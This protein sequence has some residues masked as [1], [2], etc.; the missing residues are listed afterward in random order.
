[1]CWN[2][3]IHFLFGASPLRNYWLLTF[4]TIIVLSW[5]FSGLK[6]RWLIE[7]GLSFSHFYNLIIAPPITLLLH[8]LLPWA[9]MKV[10]SL[11]NHK[12]L[13]STTFLDNYP[14]SCITQVKLSAIFRL[15]KLF[16]LL[17]STFQNKS[18]WRRPRALRHELMAI[19]RSYLP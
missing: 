3:R 18:H 13:H 5:S 17:C 2:L 9:L 16:V 1:M 14:S 4:I 6:I 19:V 11:Q 8:G 7:V 15:N 10:E 12:F